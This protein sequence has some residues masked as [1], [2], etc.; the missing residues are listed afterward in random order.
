MDVRVC[1]NCRRLF[2]Y[3]YGP[4]ICPECARSLL[5]NKEEPKNILK[6]G[7]L[8]PLDIDEEK[9][10]EQIKDYI[11]AN[12]KASVAQ[13]AEDNE[14]TPSK[15]FEWIREDRLEFSDDSASAWFACEK[16]GAKIRSGRRC[17]RCK[18]N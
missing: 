8:K 9:T 1:K 16:C 12:P 6:A 11:M 18:T 3:I 7:L 13:I 2:N 17:N 15:L 10:F 4:E 5:E 14:I